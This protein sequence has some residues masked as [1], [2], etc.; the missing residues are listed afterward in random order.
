MNKIL[1]I[2]AS[3]ILGSKI[4]KHLPNASCPSHQE[5]DITK[6]I[7]YPKHEVV[8]LC[9]AIKNKECIQNKLLG[10]KTNIKGVCN[11]AEYCQ[12]NNSKLV[13]ISTDYVFSGNKGDYK[14][15]DELGPVNYYAETK[16]AGEI[17]V[18][19]NSDDEKENIIEDFVSII[20]SFCAKIYGQ[21]RSKRKTEKLIEELQ[22]D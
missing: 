13:Y 14:I 21:R 18:L 11:I 7:N 19:N 9:A 15:D 5:L 17:V 22:N 4:Q 2:G 6:K 10:M 8:I 16:L 20:T 12:K 1:I 3:G